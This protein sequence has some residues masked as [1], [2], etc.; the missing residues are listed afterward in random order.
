MH[1]SE[2]DKLRRD[3]FNFIE[4][5]DEIEKLLNKKND[6][7]TCIKIIN[8]KLENFEKQI[9]N[10][11]QNMKEKEQEINEFLNKN[12]TDEKNLL[13]KKNILQR[14]EEVEKINDEKDITIN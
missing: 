1:D 11:E 13:R 10:M 4:K 7:E 5:I 3:H 8:D 12:N 9:Q 2:I 14:L 6:V